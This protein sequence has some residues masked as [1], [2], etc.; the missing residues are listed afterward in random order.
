MKSKKKFAAVTL[1]LGIC[2][3]LALPG[4][5]QAKILD[6]LKSIAGGLYHDDIDFGDSASS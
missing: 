2:A 4:A 1:I 3:W 6:S 5:P